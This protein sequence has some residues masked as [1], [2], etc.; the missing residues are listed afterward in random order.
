MARQIVRP[1]IV[2]LT[3]SLTDLRA[4]TAYQYGGLRAVFGWP[5]VAGQED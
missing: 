2:D 3:L 5:P 1:D 4:L